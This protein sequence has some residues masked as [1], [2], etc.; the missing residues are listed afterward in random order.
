MRTVLISFLRL[1]SEPDRAEI[2]LWEAALKPVPGDLTGALATWLRYSNRKPK[3]FDI[4]RLMSAQGEPVSMRR[5]AIEV[6]LEH[7]ISFTKLTGR[8]RCS[9]LAH[10]RQE[11]MFRMRQVGFTQSQI[12]RF[13]G[14]DHSTVRHGVRAHAARTV[15]SFNAET[16]ADV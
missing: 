10:P 2:D 3:P 6:A 16:S 14:R 7:R 12:G 8:S 1:Y 5:I 9:D 15:P 13:F 11:A 4:L